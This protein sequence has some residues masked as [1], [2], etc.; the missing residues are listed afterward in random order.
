MQV[1]RI[2]PLSA[3]RL[4]FSSIGDYLLSPVIVRQTVSPALLRIPLA[5]S[6][7]EEE[8]SSR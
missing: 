1:Y 3:I 2:W 8:L 6:T 5:L 4:T 7:S